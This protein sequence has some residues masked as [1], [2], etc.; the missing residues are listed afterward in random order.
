M[1][2]TVAPI[3]ME[4]RTAAV[5]P[6]SFA[7]FVPLVY[8]VDAMMLSEPVPGEISATSPRP[9]A[10][11]A[12]QAKQPLEKHYRQDDGDAQINPL[13]AARHALTPWLPIVK[14]APV[15]SVLALAAQAVPTSAA[16]FP[17]TF[18]VD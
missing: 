13:L 9:S 5:N 8:K 2:G 12:G 14:R 10:S 1:A 17:W 16:T 11:E 3:A 6:D 7:A 18:P 15:D 4:H